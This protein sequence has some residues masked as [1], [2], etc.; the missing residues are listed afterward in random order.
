MSE[1][2][3]E[4]EADLE[5]LLAEHP[6]LI[7][8]DL[9]DGAEPPR[10]LL[11][12]RQAGVDPENWSSRQAVDILFVDEEAVPTLV[13][14][15]R[16]SNTEL[17]RRAVAQILDY[18][19]NAVLHWSADALRAKFAATCRDRNRDPDK[20]LGEFLAGAEEAG[21]FWRRA[22][23]NLQ[24]GRIR[25]VFAADEVPAE[26]RRI[27]RFLSR[28]MQAASVFAVEVKCFGAETPSGCVGLGTAQPP[29]GRERSRAA[30]PARRRG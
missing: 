6:E 10:W 29:W 13:E 18:A 5:A 30:R 28:Q 23:T 16:G 7:T 20:V 17:R 12:S 25:L 21:A 8:N 9:G 1:Q 15:K 11:V 19:A 26:L 4:A 27:V 22:H 2:P 24:A 3:F 14:V